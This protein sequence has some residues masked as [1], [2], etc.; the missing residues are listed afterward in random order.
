MKKF[1]AFSLLDVVFIMLINVKMP[2]IGGILTFMSR[3]NFVLSWLSWACKKFYNLRARVLKKKKVNMRHAT[4]QPLNCKLTM[5]VQLTWFTLD[6]LK[7]VASL[8]NNGMLMLVLSLLA[9][10]DNLCK[11]F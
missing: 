8:L 5:V 9:V 3:I 4:Q 1:I 7:K 11:P 6:F 10:T 2:T